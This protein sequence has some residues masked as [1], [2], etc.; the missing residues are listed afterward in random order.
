MRSLLDGTNHLLYKITD[1][2]V[3][4]YM[5]TV[6]KIDYALDQIED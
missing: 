3:A 6:E 1:N 4:D 2:L 5:P